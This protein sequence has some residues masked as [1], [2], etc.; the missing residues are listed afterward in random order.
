LLDGSLMIAEY[1]QLAACDAI[2]QQSI[3][4]QQSAIF[5]NQQSA[6]EQ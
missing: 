1:V 4:N 5:I 2:D 6:I 3:R